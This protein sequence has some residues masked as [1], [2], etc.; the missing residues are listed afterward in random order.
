[1]YNMWRRFVTF[2]WRK[3]SRFPGSLA[4]DTKSSERIG[5]RI[6]NRS[7][8]RWGEQ[9]YGHGNNWIMSSR[10]RSADESKRLAVE[11]YLE[12]DPQVVSLLAELQQRHGP[13]GGGEVGAVLVHAVGTVVYEN[14]GKVE[15]IDRSEGSGRDFYSAVLSV[16]IT[17]LPVFAFPEFPLDSRNR[18]HRWTSSRENAITSVHG[19]SD[20]IRYVKRKS[21]F[22]GDSRKN[23]TRL[24][25]FNQPSYRNMIIQNAP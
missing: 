20:S 9:S 7:G 3:G 2:V 5:G 6:D 13:S 19:G 18:F 24:V 25:W 1:M 8:I 11:R 23:R 12:E 17:F 4:R 14:R 10:S 15:T 21:G 22:F 16:I